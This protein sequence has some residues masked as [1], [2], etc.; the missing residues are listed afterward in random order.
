MSILSKLGVTIDKE[1]FSSVVNNRKILERVS[2]TTT[3]KLNQPVPYTGSINGTKLNCRVTLLNADLTYLRLKTQKQH[4]TGSEY[5]VASGTFNNVKLKLDVM[6]DGRAYDLFE[7]MAEFAADASGK[8]VDVEQFKADA[9][10]MNIYWDRGMPLFWQQF[11]ASFEKFGNLAQQFRAAGAIDRLAI[12][13]LPEDHPIKAIYS[14][15]NGIPVTE[16]ELG[17]MDR[18][19]SARYAF[20]E[21]G[22]G[23]IDL[24][25]AQY[26]QYVRIASLRESALLMREKAE[27]PETPE[28]EAIKLRDKAKVEYRMAT[29]STS[30]WGGAQQRAER[31]KNGKYLMKDIYDAVNAPCG[32]FTMVMPSGETYKADLWRNKNEE[33]SVPTN[34]LTTPSQNEPDP[35]A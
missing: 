7:I 20:D 5:Y 26:D 33:S 16:F 1:A 30:T 32:R 11:G 4:S 6:I 15:E 2:S 18:T 22:Q 10:E 8:P 23:F 28:A 13:P 24:L 35:L 31:L 25:D 19:A 3:L 21:R 34:N 29:S 14:L 27:N 9:E 17:S 12:E